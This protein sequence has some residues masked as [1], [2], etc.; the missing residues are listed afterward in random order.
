MKNYF[1][2][3]LYLYLS[4]ALW[5][6]TA[7]SQPNLPPFYLGADLSYVNELEDCGVVYRQNQKEIDP[8]QLFAQEGANIVRLRLW[9]TPDW[10][11]YGTLNDLKKSIGRAKKE[12]MAVLL[13]FHYSDNWADPA[14]QIVPAAWKAVPN[15]AIMAD[16]VYQY[17]FRV[18]Q[19]LKNEQL[20]PDFV[21]IGNETNTEILMTKPSSENPKTDW[22]RNASLL[23]A[24]LNAV[25]DFNETNDLSIKTF[26]HVAQPDSAYVWFENAQKAGLVDFDFIGLSY[27]PNWSKFDLGQ[28]GE[29]IK[30][31]KNNFKKEVMI[32]EVGYPFSF[33][34][35]DSASNVLGEHS[36][37]NGYPV[38][39]EGQLSFMLDL[40]STVRNAGGQGVIYWEA[41]WV[42][43][44]CKTQWGTGSHWENAAFFDP[45]NRNEALPVFKFFT[46]K[47]LKSN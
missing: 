29:T 28:L 3:I 2:P 39:A 20:S 6:C 43:S 32:L 8:Y 19:E 1:K 9:H 25:V 42:S 13:D 24:G 10:T 14:H 12:G 38:N 30:E 23:N 11:S 21:Q 34:N 47:N 40:V 46:H 44:N 37:L 4:L 41:A 18:L 16:S 27:Y 33:K 45:E 22:N 31:L 7:I 5:N 26:L 36:D 17:T 15:D 35:Y